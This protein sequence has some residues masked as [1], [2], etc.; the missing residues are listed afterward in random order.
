MS[1]VGARQSSPRLK[2]QTMN[3]IR[4]ITRFLA[5]ALVM[6]AAFGCDKNR[7]NTE[8]PESAD[9][10]VLLFYECAFNDIGSYMRRNMEDQQ[11]GLP[12]GHIPGKYGDV[13][14][15]YSRIAENGHTPVNSYLRR[16]YKTSKGKV[17]SDTL[18]VFGKETIAAS[19]STLSAVLTL[20]KEKFPA[21]KGY[22]MVFSSHG[23]GWLPAGYYYSP[24]RFENDHKGEVGTS[25][26]G[27]AA[28]SVGHPRL[29]V[30]EGDLPD[31]DPFYGMT[32]SI[33]QDYIKGSYYGHEMSV[34]EFADAIP[35]HLDY[36]L[37]DMCFSG[38]VEVAYGLKD[39]ADYLGLSPAEVLGDG[40]F[41][42][43]KITSFLLDRTTPD[44]EGL[45]KDSFGMYDKQNGV[46]RSATINL[47]RTDGLDN[48]ARVCSDLFRE[49][50]DTLSNAPTHLIQGYFRNGRHYFFDLMDTF[51]K[52]IS[53]EEEL[54]A[55]ND[56]IDRCVVYRE[57]TPQFLSTFDI[58]EYS[59]FS[60]YL[61]CAGT[62][63]LDSYYK[64]EPW[65]KATGLVK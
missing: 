23:S 15:V 42:Y 53:N 56:A 65:N 40:M 6:T 12:A 4:T 61:P 11:K 24:S 38:G 29:P 22:G 32:R 14:L 37:F 7:H 30:P 55:V 20:V 64:K 52:C 57:A 5:A 21:N 27:I 10:R 1:S 25:R 2:G 3:I 33:G 44:L 63:L 49:Y 46:Y 39:K 34:S 43:T 19:P 41:D 9:R 17:I 35:Y 51:R 59:G 47:V 8:E 18:K 36:L 60:I 48:L 26:Q 13:L 54:R 50:S 62:P 31:T 58:T 16:I 45:L 28:Q